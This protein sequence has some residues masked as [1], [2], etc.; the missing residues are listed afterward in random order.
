MPEAWWAG[1]PSVRAAA[2]S[3]LLD[4]EADVPISQITWAPGGGFGIAREGPASPVAQSLRTSFDWSVL[5]APKASM[6]TFAFLP[7]FDEDEADTLRALLRPSRSPSRAG[8]SAAPSPETIP[9]SPAV[10][11]LSLD[12][13]SAP[14]SPLLMPSASAIDNDN[15]ND[16]VPKST[17]QPIPK[18][19]VQTPQAK[20][21]PTTPPGLASPPTTA[22]RNT[23]SL[24]GLS[25]RKPR[26]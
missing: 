2:W 9:R 7:P 5:T 20:S 17:P 18:P 22:R 14:P 10:S 23:L 24:F 19:P 15:D 12:P 6:H 8:R 21:V 13:K 11:E 4:D 26:K 3:A 25:P 1:A 16:S